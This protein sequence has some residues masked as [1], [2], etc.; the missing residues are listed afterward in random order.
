MYDT[1]NYYNKH[2]VEFSESTLNAD[3]S[4]SRDLFVSYVKPGGK[5]LDAGCGTG[6]DIKSF[7]AMGYN[8]DAFDASEEM[9]KIAEENTGIHVMQLK[10]EDFCAKDQYD[11]IW[12]CASLLHV[13]KE[14]LPDCVLRMKRA[15]KDSGIMYMSFKYGE[16]E[17]VRGDRFFIDMNETS[18][19]DILDKCGLEIITIYVS[20]DV[21]KGRQ[22]EKWINAIVRK[23]M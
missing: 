16:G 18:I 12:A 1:I 4:Q 19:K 13:K 22:N 14:D 21:R 8:V 2:A 3:M 11:G 10:F 5:I 7:I 23:E 15:L 6:R 17:R 20:N 9:C